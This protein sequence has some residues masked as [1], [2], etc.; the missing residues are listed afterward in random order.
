MRLLQRL[1]ADRRGVSAVEF[2]LVAPVLILFYFGL[3]QT[4]SAILAL[5]RVSHVASTLGDLAARTPVIRD[6]DMAD[7]FSVSDS[8]L[9][10][11]P[12]APLKARVTSITK[13]AGGVA[14]V[15]WS[16]AKNWGARAK[17][18]TMTVPDGIIGAG[19]SA[20][21][22]EVEYDYD[23]PID[24]IAPGAMTFTR[25]FYLRPRVV[26]TITRQP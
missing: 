10:P 5:R 13:D 12:T 24:L 4:T 15:G 3:V 1:K 2:A 19:Q 17:N 9:A 23:S 16:D 20:I 18:A 14:K 11:Y 22:A 26:A 25:S 6:A 21:L 7:I 8:L